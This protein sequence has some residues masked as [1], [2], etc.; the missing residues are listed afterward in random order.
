MMKSIVCPIAKAASETPDRP[1]L[2]D[3]STSLG[4]KQLDSAVEAAV[5]NL[6]G[7][8]IKSRDVVA[9]LDSNSIP[10]AILFYAAFRM[11]FVLMPLNTRLNQ[12]DW[13]RQ[14]NMADCRLVIYGDKFKSGIGKLHAANILMID[15]QELMMITLSFF[16]NQ[17]HL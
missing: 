12:S 13:R 16:Q 6:R 11:G 4:Y 15:L 8:G 14:L 1:A 7:L 10:Y 5:A 2:I 17:I 3:A 9:I